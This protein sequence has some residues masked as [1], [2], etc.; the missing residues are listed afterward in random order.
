MN[1]ASPKQFG[2]VYLAWWE[3]RSLRMVANVRAAFGNNPG[4]RILNIVGGSHK[5]YY[6][7]YFDMMSDVK[8]IDAES[9]LR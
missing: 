2:R 4:A 3:T 6:D 1:T 8:I 5:P 7:A 9:V